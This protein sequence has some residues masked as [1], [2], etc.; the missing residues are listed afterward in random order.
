[1]VISS[2]NSFRVLFDEIVSYILFEI[3][4]ISIGNGRPREPALC[5]LYRHTFVP[6]SSGNNTG[7][8][9]PLRGLRLPIGPMLLST[10]TS[11][12]SFTAVLRKHFRSVSSKV[13][14]KVFG[15][16]LPTK[17][18]GKSP[19]E[20]W[21]LSPEGS[22]LLPIILHL[23]TPKTVAKHYLVNLA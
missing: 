11:L 12:Q 5:Q 1:L 7:N 21:G 23:Y 4:I 20:V 22:D 18:G 9:S 3:H 17:F 14:Y 13:D 10:L 19:V 15:E 16:K 8:K 6:Y 2:H